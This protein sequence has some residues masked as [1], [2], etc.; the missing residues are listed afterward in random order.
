VVPQVGGCWGGVRGAEI[1]LGVPIPA[2][3]EPLPGEFSTFRAETVHIYA[4][5]GILLDIAAVLTTTLQ[6]SENG[7]ILTPTV[8]KPWNRLSTLLPRLTRNVK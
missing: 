8:S 7:R 6:V 3:E 4:Q 2:R 1:S 5:V